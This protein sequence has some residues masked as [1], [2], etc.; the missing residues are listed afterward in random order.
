MKQQLLE[1]STEVAALRR[2]GSGPGKDSGGADHTRVQQALSELIGL[3]QKLSQGGYSGLDALVR[4]HEHLKAQVWCMHACCEVL[5]HMTSNSSECTNKHN[6]VYLAML[7]RASRA[8][9]MNAN[10][11]QGHCFIMYGASANAV[12]AMLGVVDLHSC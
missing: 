8:D 9:A 5:G 1:L 7:E 6:V 10:C 3:E 4:E 11:N 2:D 12:T